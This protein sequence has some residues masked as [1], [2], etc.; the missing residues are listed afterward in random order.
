MRTKFFFCVMNAVFFLFLISSMPT[1]ASHAR[2]VCFCL[3]LTRRC[4]Q[5]EYI[6]ILLK[7]FD[8]VALHARSASCRR[9]RAESLTTSH[10]HAPKDAP[11]TAACKSSFG[12]ILSE[13]PLS[14]QLACLDR[15]SF[16]NLAKR[17]N[18]SSSLSSMARIVE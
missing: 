6:I 1:R 16:A 8:C 17:R 11:C 9:R 12:D 2:F 13:L 3:F 15:H 14:R 5:V 7:C 4:S 18:R 10:A